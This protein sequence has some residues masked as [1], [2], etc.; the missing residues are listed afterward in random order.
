MGPP[1]EMT[2][3]RWARISAVFGQALLVPPADRKAFLDRA[4]AGHPDDRADVEDLLA[5]TEQHPDFLQGVGGGQATEI[6]ARLSPGSLVGRRLGPYNVLRHRGSGGMGAVYLAEDTQ[7]HRQVAIKA[8]FPEFG[9]DPVHR[10][11]L[12]AEA[13]ALAS[14][15]SPHVAAVYALWEEADDVFIVSEYIDG[16]DLRSAIG[17]AGVAT[18]LL[19]DV[20]IAVAKALCDAHRRGLVHRDLKPENIML[21]SEGKVK[22]VDFGLAR[23]QLR[24]RAGQHSEQT[25]AIVGT[26][27][28]MSPEQIDGRAVDFRSD[29]FSFGLVLYEAATGVHPFAGPDI[30][31]TWAA[32]QR[33]TPAPIGSHGRAG[34]EPLAP[35]IARCL[36]KEPHE[37]Y[38][39]TEHLLAD[40]ERAAAQMVQPAAPSRAGERPRLAVQPDDAVKW[41]QVHQ[42][43]VSMTYA[44]ALVVLWF[45]RSMIEL[46]WLGQILFFAALAAGVVNVTLRLFLLYFFSLARGDL[47]KFFEQ[48]DRVS[49][50]VTVSDWALQLVLA[51]AGALLAR[52]HAA[53]ATLLLVIAVATLVSS[54]VIEP[55]TTAA[56]RGLAARTRTATRK[57]GR[58][59]RGPTP[60][61]GATPP[62]G[63]T[64]PPGPTPPE[65]ES[66]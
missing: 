18:S 47:A 62:K 37:R 21:T 3:E 30:V 15:S 6:P 9:R 29:Q 65:H 27:A 56:L 11:R 55:G 25:R 8:L 26:P 41:W 66:H 38:E 42:V 10:K 46:P 36:Q 14:L 54:L 32:I 57:G 34:L 16:P 53:Y 45:V 28:Y 4:C 40:V 23:V 60:P 1:R 58:P 20:A 49:P 51:G 24:A 48:R 39:S 35:V 13:R 19:A 61:R 17:T 5:R 2:P 12:Q 31:A 44:L 52:E 33:D 50:T 22:V 43:S 7:L 64:P 63:T 59:P